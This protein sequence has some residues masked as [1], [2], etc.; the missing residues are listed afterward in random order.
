MPEPAAGP[1]AVCSEAARLCTKWHGHGRVH[2]RWGWLS[3][4]TQQNAEIKSPRPRMNSKSEHVSQHLDDDDDVS[5]DEEETEDEDG[6]VVIEDIGS[7]LSEE[8]YEV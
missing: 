6:D 2:E 3:E 5:D 1:P 7:E 4:G 8:S